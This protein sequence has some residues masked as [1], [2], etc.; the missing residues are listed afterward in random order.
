LLGN[1]F[2]S[3]CISSKSKIFGVNGN[4]DLVLPLIAVVEV[5]IAS[6]QGLEI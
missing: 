6:K 5:N 3:F 1:S 2:S 4:R